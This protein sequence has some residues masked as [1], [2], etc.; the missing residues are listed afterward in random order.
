MQNQNPF[1]AQKSETADFERL[2]DG[3]YQAACC[4]VVARDFRDYND[5]S[6][7]V[8]KVMFIFQ[9]CDGGQTYYLKT[10]PMTPVINE[11]SNMFIF[12]N[13]WTGAGLDRMAE[14]FAC[15]KMV[16]YAAQVV[17][18][19]VVGK[20]GK[21]YSELANV[22]K[23][24]KGQ[25]TAVAPDAIPFYLVKG[26]E[27]QVLAQGIT[28]KPETSTTTPAAAPADL[29]APAVPANPSQPVPQPYVTQVQSG[30]KPMV[31]NPAP[32]PATQEQI[33]DE[34]AESLPF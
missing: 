25:K 28:V 24:K 31:Q 26:C 29:Q 8:T 32:A 7:F 30:L 10:K 13:G 4:G 34:D 33:S 3:M 19:T 20:D 16:G 1:M 21:N 23:P 9:V 15:D 12:V 22:L 27:A 5:N 18:Q 2:E 17:V 14:G 6:K 11:K